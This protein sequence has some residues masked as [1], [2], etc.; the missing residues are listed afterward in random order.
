MT[1]DKLNWTVMLSVRTA[2]PSKKDRVLETKDRQNDSVNFGDTDTTRPPRLSPDR[3]R[4][5]SRDFIA[6]RILWI[7]VEPDLRTT[8]HLS[9]ELYN[10][11]WRWQS[12]LKEP[13]LSSVSDLK[14]TPTVR[15]ESCL[16]IFRKLR[17]SRGKEIV[18]SRRNTSFP[19]IPFV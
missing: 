16:H 5:L 18:Y 12:S 3:G 11:L 2:S 4:N 6:S 19:K 17:K 8:H 10:H 7:F 14:T 15:G 9:L 13:S 1:A